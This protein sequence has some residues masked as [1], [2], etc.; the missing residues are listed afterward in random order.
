MHILADTA[1][2]ACL[3][4]VSPHDTPCAHVYCHVTAVL[5][6]LLLSQ[7]V[8]SVLSSREKY[9]DTTHGTLTSVKTTIMQ[10]CAHRLLHYISSSIHDSDCSA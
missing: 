8:D 1:S 10:V 9:D 5:C 3:Q 6:D 2:A 4:C 7:Q